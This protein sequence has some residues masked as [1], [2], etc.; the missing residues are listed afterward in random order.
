M[1][2]RLIKLFGGVMDYI[3]MGLLGLIQ[4]L[5]E[6]L[7]VSSSGHLAIFK[8]LFGADFTEI[9]LTF[10]I[11]L[12]L[13]TLAAVFAVYYKDIWKLIL[14]FFG[15]VGDALHGK[16]SISE[17]Y[18][19]MVVML[20]VGSIPAA[21]AGFLIKDFV[22]DVAEKYLY[23]VGIGLLFTA[24]LLLLSDRIVSG[25]HS[26]ADVGVPSSLFVGLFQAIAILPG[27]SRSGST[28]VGGLFAGYEREFAIK[29]SF[30]L[31]IPAILGAA[32]FDFLDVV[33]TG[34]NL[35]AGPAILGVIV[36][37]GSG[38][39]AIR[40]LLKLIKSNKFHLFSYYCAAA[41]VLTIILSIVK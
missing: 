28:I 40:F 3:K 11:L 26:V 23:V 39:L 19:K 24:L 17:P 9:P 38:F 41:G 20:V 36:S 5:T 25:R 21:L 6:F 22:E 14:A 4:G 29:F 10:D 13:G 31:S 37:A 18:R 30:L 32:L 16:P 27:V 8:N 2:S 1:F 15:M 34:F 7:P 33:K 35:P 12:H